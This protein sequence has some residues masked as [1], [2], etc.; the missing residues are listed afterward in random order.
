[1]E[2]KLLLEQF[3]KDFAAMQRGMMMQF[4]KLP[5]PVYVLRA[6]A[7]ADGVPQ[8]FIFVY[9]NSACAEFLGVRGKILF[10]ACHF[11]MCSTTVI[12]SG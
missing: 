3:N 5:L 4:D 9:D 10:W 1:M 11:M 7:D 12:P 2:K 6:E 8:D